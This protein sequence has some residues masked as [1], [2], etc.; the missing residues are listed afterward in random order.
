MLQFSVIIPNYNHAPFLRERINS[1][2]DQTFQDFELIILDDASI[3][4]SKEI[5]DEFRGH[6][7]ISQ[8]I[9]NEKNSGLQSTQ[10]LKGIQLAQYDLIW[11]AESDDIADPAFLETAAD[12][13][14]KTSGSS[15]FYCDSYN[16]VETNEEKNDLTYKAIK[17]DFFETQK[18]SNDYFIKG[19][20]EINNSLKF[21]CTIN[22]VSAAVFPKLPA[23]RILQSFPHMRYYSDWL[24][25]IQLLEQ[26]EAIY[27]AETLNWYR[28]HPTSHFNASPDPL[29]RRKECFAILDYLLKQNYISEKDKL[30]KFFTEQYLGFGLKNGMKLSPA[31]FKNY[32]SINPGLFFRFLK[33][34]TLLKLSRKKVKY[35]F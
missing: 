6:P 14:S 29:V 34:F 24:F 27:T 26:C 18:W 9:Y 7:K 4:N 11:I 22:N 12:S 33:Y 15:L 35:I 23:L 28:A 10:W 25:F 13:I 17:N 3:D 20:D 8:I 21:G 5:I 2:L 31:L 30:I 19:I 1:I 16:L 32:I